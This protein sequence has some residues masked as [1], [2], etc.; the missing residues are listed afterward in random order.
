MHNVLFTEGQCS[1]CLQRARV[2]AQIHTKADRQ[3]ILSGHMCFGTVAAFKFI[4]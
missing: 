3:L 4:G 2:R 1:R